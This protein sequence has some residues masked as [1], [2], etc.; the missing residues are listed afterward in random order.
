MLARARV[1]PQWVFPSYSAY[2]STN[3]VCQDRAVPPSELGDTSAA[4]FAAGATDAGAY[5]A[6]TLAG[7]VT[8]APALA[9]EFTGDSLPEGWTVQPWVEGGSGRLEGGM[10]VLDG[11]MVG[12][13]PLMLSPRSVEISAVFAARP[14]QLAGLG[15]DF[16]TE[17]WVMFSTKWGR[18]FYGRTHLLQ[19]EDTKLSPGWFEAPHVFRIDWNVLDIV[20]SVDGARQAQL[21]IPIPGYMRALAANQRLGGEPLRVE[22]VRLS[23]YAPAGRFTSRVLD[24]GRPCVWGP[25]RWEAGAPPGTSVGLEVRTGDTPRPGR[26]WSG[27]RVVAHSGDPVGGTTRHLQYRAQLATG[28]PSWTPALRRVCVSY[29]D[30]GGSSS[31]SLGTGSALGCQ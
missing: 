23:P 4:D 31:S 25:L 20:F 19:I 8:L 3:R 27:W 21:M 28:H 16:V 11:A 6:R 24:A 15:V 5:V 9:A 29:S 14:D 13:G 22:W 1:G 2:D 18:R 7:E 10:L 30:A 26:A 17:P 12:S